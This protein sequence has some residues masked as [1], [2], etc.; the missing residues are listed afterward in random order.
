M[1]IVKR[2]VAPISKTGRN[3]TMDN[4]YSSI[5][6]SL[7]LLKNRNLTMVGTIVT[8]KREILPCFLDTKK[9]TLNSSVFGYG[10]D[11]LLTSYVPKKK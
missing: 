4:W 6:L 2:M 11:I 10:E 7:D 5:P 3:V 8:N 1:S 9:R